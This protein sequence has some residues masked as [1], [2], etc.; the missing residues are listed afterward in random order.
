MQGEVLT[1]KFMFVFCFEK[2]LMII[3]IYIRNL[4]IR[5]YLTELSVHNKLLDF[6]VQLAN[7]L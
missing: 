4:K 3:R 5:V 7:S 6:Y 1:F 2:N